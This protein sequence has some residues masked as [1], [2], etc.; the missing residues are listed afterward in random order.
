MTFGRKPRLSFRILAST[1]LASLLLVLAL[2][3]N[4][5]WHQLAHADAHEHS[6][7][8]GH[9][10]DH[11]EHSCAVDLFLSG[12][13]DHAAPAPLAVAASAVAGTQRFAAT[14]EFVASVFLSGSIL[15]HAPPASA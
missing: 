9:E 8:D 7:H 11:G 15:E 6:E 3:A 13:V 4:P 1:L 2:A 14:A 10:H 12:S 5:H